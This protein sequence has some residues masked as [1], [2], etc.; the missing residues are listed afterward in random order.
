MPPPVG[1][2]QKTSK[3]VSWLHHARTSLYTARRESHFQAA[4][5]LRAACSLACIRLHRDFQVKGTRER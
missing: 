4:G 5:N 3:S 1:L 2:T